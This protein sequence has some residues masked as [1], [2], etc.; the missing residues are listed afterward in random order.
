MKQRF[1]LKQNVIVEPLINRWHA[2]SY[3]LPPH[4]ASMFLVN[5]HLKIMRSFV[6]SP[7][8]HVSASRNP[9]MRG[10][11]FINYPASKVNDIKRLLDK[12]TGEEADLVDL[13]QAIGTLHQLL[14]KEGTG[15]SLETLYQKIPDVLKGYVEL[16]Y[17][18]GHRPSIRFIEGLLYKSGYYKTSRQSVELSLGSEV[19]RPFAFS[20]PRL[21]YKGSLSLSIPFS[22]P[23]LDDLMR[24]RYS[25]GALE[26]I[27]EKLG[28][29]SG[30]EPRF[31][32]FFTDQA[33]PP[34]APPAA[35]GVRIR[36]FG[37]ASVLI[38]ANGVNVLTDPLISYGG[39]GHTPCYNYMDLPERIHAVL[40]THHHQ[41]HCAL[42]TLLQLRH[43]TGAII[44]PRSGGGNLAD[45]SMKLALENIG[46][47]NVT[48]ID[49]FE[50]ISLGAQ[51]V[52]GL[53]FLGEHGD[54]GVRTKMA[55][56]VR[57]GRKSVMLVADSNNLEPKLYEH[58]HSIVGSV[59][60]LFLG[61]ECDGAPMSWAYGPLFINPPSRGMDQ[62]RRLNGSDCRKGLALIDRLK[63][64]RVYV[65]AMGQEPWLNFI[66]SIQYTKESRPI[67]ESDRL[68][69]ECVARGIE[70]ERLFGRKE[71][72][73]PDQYSER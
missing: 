50:T 59:D 19:E 37:H 20:S 27:G 56:L 60:I 16:T 15:H 38:E 65:Y 30:E 28:V 22:R 7:Q 35:D 73:L 25:P 49:E 11:P 51:S 33:I 67:V 54:L 55:Y 44:V 39:D 45:P 4:V 5:S 53:P 69:Q 2:W 68:V 10:G 17:D 32:A 42:E 52:T 41:D 6:N 36:Y 72:L 43:K 14:E 29:A 8:A 71:I 18:L 46:F 13:G 63:P 31:S 24:M 58:I 66:T 12:T 3:L 23:E 48:E 62:S 70:S 64:A 21:D 1:Y 40:I 57:I 61:M 47:R 26:E 9:E 34:K